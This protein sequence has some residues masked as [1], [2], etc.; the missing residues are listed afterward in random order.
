MT[1][2]RIDHHDMGDGRNIADKADAIIA[3]L[4]SPQ[5][6]Q[7]AVM[8]AVH[9]ATVRSL[10]AVITAVSGQVRIL[11]E[12]VGQH[13][14]RHPDAEIYLPQPGAGTILGAQ[15][16]KT[17]GDDLH[18]PPSSLSS[19]CVVG[20]SLT[21]RGSGSVRS[22]SRLFLAALTLSTWARPV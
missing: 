16:L 2:L 9:A 19:V 20:A 1:G 13:L 6:G 4:P 15:V 22:I 14:R 12:Q 8:I 21:R 17:S 10:I 11:E 5:L 3:A 7:P 18:R